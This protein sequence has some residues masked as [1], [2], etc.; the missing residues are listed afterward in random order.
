MI[1]LVIPFYNEEKR[2]ADTARRAVD[3]LSAHFSDFELLLVDDGSTDGSAAALLPLCGERVK[4]LGYRQNRGKGYA[5]KTGIMAAKGD[6][7]FFLDADLA[8]G[9][10]VLKPACER[11]MSTKADILI[12]SRRLDKEGYSRYP[13][14]RKAA[15]HSFALVVNTLLGL[16]VTD[17]QCGFKGFKRKAAR[18]VFSRCKTDGFAFDMEALYIAR[19]MGLVIIEEPV[20]LLVHGESK[21][22]VVRDS[23]RMFRDVLRVRKSA[24]RGAKNGGN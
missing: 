4:L 19:G 8:Y 15:S 20:R 5:V 9:L 2:I 24:E 13:L 1:S 21:V 14:L 10:E 18:E 11:L 17:S 16:R 22:R 3:Y 23:V 6:A 12:G 7:V